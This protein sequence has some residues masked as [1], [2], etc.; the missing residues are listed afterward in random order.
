[1]IEVREW[2]MIHTYYQE[3]MPIS[4]IAKEVGV[5]R[6]TVYR[7]LSQESYQVKER[8][9]KSS[10]LD[11]YKPY[12][13]ERL[14]KYNLTATRLF[15]E[16][17]AQGYSGS[18]DTVKKFVASIRGEQPGPACVRFET[19]PGEQAQVDWSPAGQVEWGGK[20]IK[21]WCFSM[22]LGYSRAMYIEFTTSQDLITFIRCHINAFKYFGGVPWTILYDNPKVVVLSREG[23]AIQW[24]PK[25]LE[26]S[27]TYGFTPIL[28]TPRRPQTKGKVERPY[29]Y[30]KQDFLLGTEAND[31]VDLNQKARIWLDEVANC[32]VH[33]TTGEIPF[34]RLREEKLRPLPPGEYTINL[35]E[36]RKVSKDF[37]ISYEGNYY[38]VPFVLAGKEVTVR[39]TGQELLI[40]YRGEEVA[41]HAKV[42]G[43]GQIIRDPRHEVGI[44]RPSYPS[45]IAEVR[46]SFLE[47]FPEA[48]GFLAGV[49]QAKAGN[50]RYHLVEVLKLLED[51]PKEVVRQV[52]ARATEYKAF[53]A[54]TVRKT[55]AQYFK[56]PA[57]EVPA[58]PPA[59]T[60]KTKI[61]IGQVA[62]RPLEEYALVAGG[63]N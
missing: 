19:E 63:E 47:H 48:E 55:C 45:R 44:P 34:K 11:P 6:K 28:C 39:D 61:E 56:E 29:R 9:T 23:Q 1:M 60:V 33:R 40:F 22:V 52:I 58:P 8:K 50:A 25:F 62:V 2:A 14:S 13:E 24:N 7:A 21:L 31:V 49:V 51:Y 26:F 59:P 32:R 18:Y 35:E 5:D 42:Q 36:V 20:K 10:I 4:R 38:S 30:I 17:K 41:R 15:R 12:I 46:E 3:G 37:V 16:I 57:Q 27:R 54:R 53:D 43:K